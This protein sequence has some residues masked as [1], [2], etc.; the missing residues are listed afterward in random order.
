MKKESATQLADERL[1]ER[2]ARTGQRFTEQRRRVYGVLLQHRDHPSAEEVF[3]RAKQ[4]MPEISMATVYNT[5]DT[6]V[7]CGLLRQVKQDRGA[8]RYCSNMKQHHHFYCEACGGTFD[9]D[10]DG[11]GT[12]RE[13]RLPAGFKM[14]SLDLSLRGLCPECSSRPRRNPAHPLS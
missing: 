2:L 8:T 14:R 10:F 12:D 7:Q 4:V 13:P 9:V 5:L 6:L 11:L 1:N 3:L